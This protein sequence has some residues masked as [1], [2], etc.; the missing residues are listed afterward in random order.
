[1]IKKTLYLS[2][3]DVINWE[4]FCKKNFKTKRVLSKVITEAMEEYIENFDKI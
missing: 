1:M 3:N 4:E 2:K